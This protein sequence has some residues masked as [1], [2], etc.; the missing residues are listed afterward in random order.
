MQ[1]SNKTW[2]IHR[3]GGVTASNMKSAA[4][5]N[6][7]MPSQSLIKRLCYPEAFKFFPNLHGMFYWRC[8]SFP[9]LCYYA[10]SPSHNVYNHSL[11][12]GVAHIRN[13]LLSRIPTMLQ[14]VMKVLKSLQLGCS[15]TVHERPFV[16]AS[17]DR[18]ITCTCCGKGVLEVKCPYCIKDGLPQEDQENF[19]MTQKNGKWSLRRD[20]AYYY[21]V[22]AQLNVCKLTYCDFVVWTELP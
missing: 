18:I 7:S 10:Y 12:G 6:H 8:T 2:F 21:Q 19:C 1:S 13:L 15:L 17:P 3:A 5:T 20:H 16:G 14:K 11:L 4:R 9:I 22:Q